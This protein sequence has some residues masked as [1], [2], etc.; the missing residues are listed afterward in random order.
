MY[1]PMVS[2]I[3]F[4]HVDE[5]YFILV[6]GSLYLQSSSIILYCV[7]IVSTA[8]VSIINFC[9]VCSVMSCMYDFLRSNIYIQSYITEETMAMV[10]VHMD[11]ESSQ[12]TTCTYCHPHTTIAHLI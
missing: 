8:K 9:V 6:C 1:V 7:Y 11:L 4:T 3:N 2:Y 12:W 5:Q 10:E